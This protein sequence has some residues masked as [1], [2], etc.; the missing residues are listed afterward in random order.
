MAS[1][2]AITKTLFAGSV[3]A[4]GGP[5]KA[6]GMDQFAWAKRPVV[7]FA[8][9]ESDPHAAQQLDL[10]QRASSE[11]LDRDV[12]VIAVWPDRVEG[13]DL[14]VNADMLRARYG[15]AQGTFAVLLIGKDTG[16]K[17]RSDTVID[18]NLLF[19]QIDSMP[20]RQREM[21]TGN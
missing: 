16:V 19:A 11:R 17:R 7:V 9:S 13:S 21:R 14:S 6:A 3:L 4:L 2:K 5:V 10:L 15:I 8:A 20:M 18:P 1:A 12:I